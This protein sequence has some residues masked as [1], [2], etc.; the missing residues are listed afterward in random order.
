M[1]ASTLD[2]SNKQQDLK[3]CCGDVLNAC[4]AAADPR[5]MT[6]KDGSMM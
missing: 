1:T 4:Y 2:T 3:I 5:R 6:V